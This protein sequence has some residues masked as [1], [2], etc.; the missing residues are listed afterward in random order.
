VRG[1]TTNAKFHMTPTALIPLELHWLWSATW[2]AA[3]LAAVVLLVQA[4]GRNFLSPSSR[5][6]LWWLVLIRLCLPVTPESAWSVFNLVPQRAIPIASGHSVS[7]RAIPEPT[8]APGVPTEFVPA[9]SSHAWMASIDPAPAVSSEWVAMAGAAGDWRVNDARNSVG[10]VGAWLFWIWLIGATAY[11]ARLLTAS[12]LLDRHLR[13]QRPLR[14][15]AIDRL[16]DDCRQRM[17][18]RRQMDVIET[19][20]VRSPALFGLVRPR[21]L[22]PPGVLRGFTETDLRHVLMHEL[23]HLRRGDLWLNWWMVWIQ[24]V[25][26]FNPLVWL[27]FARIRSDRELACDA[28]AMART[29]EA[30]RATYGQTVLKL[31]ER[32][33]APSPVPGSVGVLEDRRAIE[34]RVE[35][36]IRFRPCQ[37]CPWVVVGLWLGLA[38][39]TLTDGRSVTA[40]AGASPAAQ[41]TPTATIAVEDQASMV[42][43][44]KEVHREHLQ[45]IVGVPVQR[46]EEI[47]DEIRDSDLAD[48][49]IE[50][51]LEVLRTQ[52]T[53]TRR[54]LPVGLTNEFEQSLAARLKAIQE[55]V[56]EYILPEYQSATTAKRLIELAEQVLTLPYRD[57]P[58]DAQQR[59]KAHQQYAAV[60][61]RFERL[62]QDETRGLT[63]AS[64]VTIEAALHRPLT[65]V[66]QDIFRP[67]YGQPL[68]E[69][70]EAELNRIVDRIL[71]EVSALPKAAENQAG[72]FLDATKVARD[73]WK[74]IWEFNRSR[75]AFLGHD[76]SFLAAIHTWRT[77]IASIEQAI[78][79]ALES[80]ERAEWDATIN[81]IEQQAEKDIRENDP[82][83]IAER[84][85][86]Q[87]ERDIQENS[88]PNGDVS[89]G[90][91]STD[92]LSPSE[93]AATGLR[94][95]LQLHLGSSIRY[96]HQFSPPYRA[97]HGQPETNRRQPAPGVRLF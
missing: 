65:D 24:A 69:M 63:E 36:I 82:H 50:G 25:H 95:P 67:G 42:D 7:D 51:A 80:A 56:S 87:E 79:Q 18:I 89:T 77:D 6:V 39:L 20:R 16:L 71:E 91:D 66:R 93:P 43:G 85:R 55:S 64:K 90:E 27:L 81:R 5:F 40:A 21:L 10:S 84:I 59:Q 26:W 47:L 86:Q 74:A 94:S 45:Q 1:A 12:L 61:E 11:G 4:F 19:A 23:A 2:Q 49:N 78:G 13:R 34:R 32:L 76:P 35:S 72:E 8:P 53:R 44:G 41:Q 48:A 60:L 31:L 46:A 37:R 57:I 68:S 3:V 38:G 73:G 54:E 52:V 83:T 58:D 9:A 22:I 17:G 70:E 88:T 96:A 62:V 14:E 28:L 29:A 30:D 97:P 75:R 15:P 92:N 33:A